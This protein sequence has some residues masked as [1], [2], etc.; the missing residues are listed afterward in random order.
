MSIN[1]KELPG[2]TTSRKETR[3]VVITYAVAR[4]AK[5]KERAKGAER[6]WSVI[7]SGEASEGRALR[8]NRCSH[9]RRQWA[10]CARVETSEVSV[11]IGDGVGVAKLSH[12]TVSLRII[13]SHARRM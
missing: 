7:V 9:E 12:R 10:R 13:F 4:N 5:P 2:K 1:A 11:V 8:A 6:P 3:L